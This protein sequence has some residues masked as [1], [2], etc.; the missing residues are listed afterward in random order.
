MLHDPLRP[1]VLIRNLHVLDQAN[2]Q[3]TLTHL[4]LELDVDEVGLCAVRLPV[5]VLLAIPQQVHAIAGF[6]GGHAPHCLLPDLAKAAVFW[7]TVLD[8][9]GR[10]VE[11]EGWR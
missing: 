11:R 3:G 1:G 7:E 10:G 5:C 8:C 4:S 6:C 2:R 9:R